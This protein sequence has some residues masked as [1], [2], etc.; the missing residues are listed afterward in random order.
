MRLLVPV[1]LLAAVLAPAA[2]AD[3]AQFHS[4]ARKTGSASG[5][6]YQ[7]YKDVWW[8]VRVPGNTTVEASPVVA[9]GIVVI[10]GWDKVVRAFDAASGKSKWNYTMTD[11]VVSSPAIQSGRVYAMD[12]KG[13]LVSLDL[14]TGRLYAT[15]AVGASLAPITAHEGKLFIG[16]EAGEMKAFDV[17]SSDSVITLL[18]TFSMTSFRTE[19]LPSTATACVHNKGQIRTAAAVHDG[20]VYFG[21]MNNHV[22]AINEEGESDDTT[23][24]QWFNQTGDIVLA[25]PAVD[26]TNT[27]VHFASYDGKVRSFTITRPNPASCTAGNRVPTWTYTATDNQ[28]FRS[29]PAIDGTRLYIGTNAGKVIA[30]TASSG[31][32]AWTRATNDIIVSSPAVANGVVV[33]GSDDK[34]VYW[35]SAA[36]GTILRQFAAESAIKSSPAIDGSR[37]FVASFDGT[38]YMFGPEIPKRPDLV[39]QSIA[40]AG[41]QASVVVKNAGD[42]ASG[43][44]QLRLLRGGTFLANVNVTAID[45]GQT[46]TLTYALTIPAAESVTVKAIIDPDGTVA[47]SNESNNELS[48]SLV[49]PI[50]EEPEDDGGGGG[51]GIKIPGPGLG[52]LL[53]TLA[54][55][56]LALRRRRSA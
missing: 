19:A 55:A 6:D 33:V 52:A 18:W 31:T 8:N 34:N 3:W 53:G 14:Q 21:A 25:S 36:N 51:G 41:G 54:L 20:I 26:V 40:F 24:L 49:A 50:E 5:T 23:R 48:K 22:Y 1:L 44:T 10:G 46:A 28:Q 9:G 29:S 27:K 12:V 16:T 42:A 37:A 35:L 11:K 13:S 39:V 15:A 56:A 32:E 7:V 4:D 17:K 38:V 30:I 2:Q 45:P 47:E 43:A